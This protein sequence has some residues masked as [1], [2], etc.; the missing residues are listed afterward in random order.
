MKNRLS[1]EELK[2]TCPVCE[3]GTLTS[4]LSTNEVE[5]KGTKAEIPIHYSECD[6]CMSEIATSEQT[7]ENKRL[8]ENF[9]STC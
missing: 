2:P 5:H 8:I 1:H 3:N 9:K 4:K 6:H 7:K